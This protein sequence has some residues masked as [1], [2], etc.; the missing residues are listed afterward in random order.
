METVM[1]QGVR[2]VSIDREEI[3]NRIHILDQ[4]CQEQESQI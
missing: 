3:I 2:I 1:L 4:L